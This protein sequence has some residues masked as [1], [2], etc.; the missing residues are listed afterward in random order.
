MDSFES[1]EMHFNA[2]AERIKKQI[3][4]YQH[5]AEEVEKCV[6]RMK[7]N[8][9]DAE[10]ERLEMAGE[11]FAPQ[12]E[13]EN[14]RDGDVKPDPDYFILYPDSIQHAPAVD[15]SDVCQVTTSIL[16]N[17]YGRISATSSWR[18]SLTH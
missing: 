10:Q 18:S 8:D 6:E 2:V 12:A 14:D 5:F 17:M 13:Q 9:A 7:Q 1:A 16:V 4:H 15:I 3:Q 11:M